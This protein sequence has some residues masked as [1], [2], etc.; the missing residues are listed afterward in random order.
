MKRS[1]VFTTSEEIGT[2]FSVTLP[3]AKDSSLQDGQHVVPTTN[4]PRPGVRVLLAED[5]EDL[6][7]LVRR[8]LEGLRCKVD[9]VFNGEEAYKKIKSESFDL[10]LSDVQMPKLSGKEV[11]KRIRASGGENQPVFIFMSGG[12]SNEF[13]ADG[14]PST[15]ATFLR[16]PFTAR[17]LAMAIKELFP[18]EE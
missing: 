1:I 9:T 8:M 10:V 15:D 14:N 3:V 13:S 6:A 17:D 7:K 2:T 18:Q 16:K 11:M 12:I 5:E 4:L